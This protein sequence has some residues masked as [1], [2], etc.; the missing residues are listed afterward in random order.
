MG[1]ESLLRALSDLRQRQIQKTRIAFGNRLSALD[2]GVDNAAGSMQREIVERWMLRFEELEKELNQ[3]LKSVVMDHPMYDQVVA[4]KGIGNVLAARLLAPID[5]E[6]ADTVSSLWCYVYGK[7]EDGKR[8]YQR[9]GVRRSYNKALKST[10]WLICEQFLRQDGSPYQK[11]YYDA[12]TYYQENRSDW[13]PM[14]IHRAAMRKM[15]K[16]FLA[17][18]WERW[19]VIE[20]LPIRRLYV[21]EKLGHNHIS[22]PEDFGWLSLEGVDDG[23]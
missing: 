7:V 1:Q 23:E 4:I 8:E 5:I 22:H 10:V 21:Q 9:K 11:V 15:G 12:K 18:L 2:R 20:G 17:H 16:T 13:T 3:D 19:R 6:R 14:R